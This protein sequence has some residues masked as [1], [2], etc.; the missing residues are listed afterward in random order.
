MK[1]PKGELCSEDFQS[2]SVLRE[3][4]VQQLEQ[5]WF[6]L[7][8]YLFFLR[9]VH[10]EKSVLN[11]LSA[12]EHDKLALANSAQDLYANFTRIGVWPQQ[13]GSA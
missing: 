8:I 11:I 12:F 13:L 4:F 6:C 10:L 3:G 7:F 2:F 5:L 9:L 1:H